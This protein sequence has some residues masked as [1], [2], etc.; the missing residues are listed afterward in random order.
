M[1]VT[2]IRYRDLAIRERDER[3]RLH[4][5]LNQTTTTRN[6]STCRRRNATSAN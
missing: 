4:N 6:P 2:K 3:L 5:R 1:D